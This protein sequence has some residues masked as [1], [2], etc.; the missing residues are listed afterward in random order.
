[1]KPTPIPF[2]EFCHRVLDLRLTTGQRAIALVTFDGKTPCELEGKER[3]VAITA[4]GELEEIPAVARRVVVLR[5]GRASGKSTLAAA[6]A[7]YRLVTA[8]LSGCGPH[9]LAAVLVTTPTRGL[10]VEMVRAA[11][12]LVD[13]VPAL[14]AMVTASTSNGFV[15]RRQDGR[16]VTFKAVPKSRGGASARGTSIITAILDEAE[17][18][19]NEES[20]NAPVRD[21]DLIAG[22]MPRLI[23]GG[24]LLLMSTPWP[25]VS[26]TSEL[27]DRN[28]TAP[29]TALCARAPTLLM[30]DND[31]IIAAMVA[32]ERERDELNAAREY[33][34]AVVAAGALFFDPALIA[35]AVSTV[36]IVPQRGSWVRASAAVDLGFRID[37]SALVVTQWQDGRLVVVHLEEMRPR[38]G[39]P[40]VPSEVIVRFAQ[41]ARDLGATFLV[42]DH[43]YIESAREH[44]AR[45]GLQVQAGAG[46]LRGKEQS[47]VALRDMFREGRI[48]I[49]NDARLISQLRSV[50]SRALPGGGLAITS[51]RRAGQHGDLISALVL[52]AFSARDSQCVKVDEDLFFRVPHHIQCFH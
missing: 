44:S 33:D 22:M 12:V 51:P 6:F 37:P 30:R 50:T 19:P 35:R 8:D 39:A 47:F 15:L 42:A 29:S 49:P 38:P 7:I 21:S 27:F 45:V 11:R 2:A 16:M 9:D 46:G 48:V 31:P 14:R 1:M 24:C 25:I 10:A 28:F 43:H 34:C 52:A 13:R 36:Q 40:L 26:A 17:F 41:T 32:S 20:A 23:G 4:F 5:C 3:E 18:L